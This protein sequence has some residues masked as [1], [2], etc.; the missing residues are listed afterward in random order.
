MLGLS[1][2]LPDAL[3]R[4]LELSAKLGEGGGT[5]VAETVPAY[6]NVPMALGEPLDSLL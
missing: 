4:N 2:E 5:P 3:S 1:L 6:Q